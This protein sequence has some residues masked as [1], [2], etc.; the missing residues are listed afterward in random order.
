MEILDQVLA[1]IARI[2]QAA[3]MVVFGVAAGWFTLRAFQGEQGWQL[4]AVVFGVFFAFVGWLTR[5]TA[6]GAL[7]GFLLG[8]AGAIIFWGMIK[9]KDQE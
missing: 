7:G 3:G 2:S 4:K 8:A 5:F 9:G 6:P 1:V